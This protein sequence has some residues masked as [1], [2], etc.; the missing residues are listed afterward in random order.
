MKKQLFE[1]FNY[2]W[3]NS[4]TSYL[5]SRSEKYLTLAW[6]YSPRRD[7]WTRLVLRIHSRFQLELSIEI[8]EEEEGG[9][10]CS[11]YN[12]TADIQ[13]TGRVSDSIS[14]CLPFQIILRSS[15]K[16]WQLKRSP[17][18][19]LLM[20]LKRRSFTHIRAKLF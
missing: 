7:L 9:Q 20:E 15:Q 11:E 1:K 12:T 19:E 16:S 17:Q 10:A 5:N 8:Y 6:Y 13:R 3:G 2:C 4:L 14:Y 18:Q